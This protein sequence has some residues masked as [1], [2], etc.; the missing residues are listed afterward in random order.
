MLDPTRARPAIR[1]II[2]ATLALVF[3]HSAIAADIGK[4]SSPDSPKVTFYDLTNDHGA[5]ATIMNFGATLVKL[6]VPDK[7]G[8]SADVVL[9]FDNAEPYIEG[10][11][12]YFGS[13]VGRV[14]NRIA[15]GT[16]EIAG[17]TQRYF[18]PINNGVNSLHGGFRGYDKRIWDADAVLTADGPAVRFTLVDNDGEEGYPGTVHVAVIYTLTETNVLRIQYDATTDKPTP[19]NLTNHAYFNLK[20]DGA[21]DVLGHE[22]KIF[23]DHDTPTDQTLIPTGEIAPVKGTPLDFTTAKP[24]GRDIGAFPGE[25]GGYDHNFVLT[26]QTGKLAEAA[27]VY[28][29]TTGRFLQVFTTEPGIQF[30]S[31]NFL[32]GT[33]TGKGKIT[34]QKHTAFALECQHYPDSVNHISFPSTLLLPTQTYHQLTEYRFSVSEKSPW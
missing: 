1:T 12:P 27:D 32:D 15:L 11:S 3:A 26:N 16:F 17:F 24:I 6:S 25:T 8:K 4:R 9:G 31:G 20:D 2:A 21:T 14:A 19:I 7:N 10:R 34:Y 23:G 13:I 22:L 18:V 30:Y 28:E 33:L 5:S 29:P